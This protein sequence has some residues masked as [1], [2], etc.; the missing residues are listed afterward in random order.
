LTVEGRVAASRLRPLLATHRFARALTSPATRARDTAAAAGFGDAV[1]DADLR[2]WDYG[3]LEGVTTADIRA[4]GGV[5]A[6]WTVWHGPVPGGETIDDVARRARRVVDRA[7][8]AG[9]DVV[10]FGHGHMSRVLAAVALGLD[11][12]DGARLVLDP[13]TISVVGS[14]HG[15]RALRMWN[16]PAR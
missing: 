12:H 4:R 8:A 7:G 14:E 10:C 1:V 6:D 11:P 16:A 13:A 2:E 15:R 5:F 3:E 9:G